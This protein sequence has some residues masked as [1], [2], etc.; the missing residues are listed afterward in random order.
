M[1]NTDFLK[2]A[3]CIEKSELNKN[4]DCDEFYAFDNDVFN[5]NMLPSLAPIIY[6]EA[7]NLTYYVLTSNAADLRADVIT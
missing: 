3:V 6:T 2:N 4:I 5:Y 1:F 7:Q